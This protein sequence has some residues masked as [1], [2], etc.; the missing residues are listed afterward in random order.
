MSFFKDKELVNKLNSINFNE[1]TYI[2][3]IP[4]ELHLEKLSDTSLAVNRVLNLYYKRVLSENTNISMINKIISSG[5]WILAKIM[6]FWL[7]IGQMILEK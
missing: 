1:F 6:K 2:E 7:L 4:S 5:I 3:K